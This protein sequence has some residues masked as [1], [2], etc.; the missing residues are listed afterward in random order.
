MAFTERVHQNRSAALMGS[1]QPGVRAS[2]RDYLS[3]EVAF[4]ER[5][6][7]AAYLGFGLAEIFDLTEAGQWYH[8]EALTAML[9]VAPEQAAHGE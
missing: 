7:T 4:G 9:L 8:A 2:T 6:K 3:R 5:A 1:A